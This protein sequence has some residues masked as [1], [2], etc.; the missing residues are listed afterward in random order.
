MIKITSNTEG[1]YALLNCKIKKG[2]LEL[3]NN[4]EL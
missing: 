2:R 3:L 4:N 1:V